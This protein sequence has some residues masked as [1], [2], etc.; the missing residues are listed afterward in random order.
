[1]PNQLDHYAVS[2][3]DWRK[4]LRQN[5]RR[6]YIIISLFF[7][8]YC[9]IGLLVDMYLYASAYPHATIPALFTALVTFRLFPIATLIMLGIA[10]IS[11]LVSYT[12]YDRL[13]LLGTDY[14][15]ITPETAQN[16]RE[17]QLYN[18]VEEMKIASGLRYM[19][20]VFIIDADYMNAFA[21]GYSEKSAMVAITRGL[22]EKLNRDELQAV[23]AHE[24]SHVRHLD[25]K[26]T[27]TA[28]LLANLTIMVLDILFYNAIFSGRRN[29]SRSKN[30]LATIIIL[31]RYTLPLISVLLLL[32]LSRTRELM[33]DAG[34]VE[35]MRTNQPLA[36]A[37]IKIQEDHI[38]NR[39]QYR[40]AYQR[41]PHE[42]VRRE[43]YIFDPFEAG[44]KSVTSASDLFS[45]HPSLETRLEA[46]GFKRKI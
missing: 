17:R 7:L 3:A 32:Y 21:S 28:S 6:T 45:T 37:L 20:K 11:L 35:L 25:I 39:D 23:M 26:L 27:L 2:T 41:T 5:N 12:L 31:L 18:V 22:M 24:L 36:S 8:I 42:N 46:L 1:M 30:S 10:A 15:E 19:P 34:C 9:G 16:T 14:H 38:Q 4:A 13:M 44:I 33:A 40:A 43:A 29:G